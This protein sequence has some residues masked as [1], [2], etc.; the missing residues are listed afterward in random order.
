MALSK[1]NRSFSMHQDCGNPRK[2]K[3]VLSVLLLTE[4][5]VTRTITPSNRDGVA[6]YLACHVVMAIL[7][8]RLYTSL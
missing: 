2:P 7:H 6:H 5:H 1:L 3:A 8:D 4:R